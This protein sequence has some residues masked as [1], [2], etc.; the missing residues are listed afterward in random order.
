MQIL[1][2]NLVVVLCNIQ[3]PLGVQL[4][5]ENRLNEMCLIMDALHS[6]VPVMPVTRS[7]ETPQSG[8]I[9]HDDF[10]LSPILFGGDQLAVASSEVES[11]A[12]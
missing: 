6:Y 3:V 2:A 11:L 1:M 10:E 8:V 7:C 9:T 5:N 4:H 12:M